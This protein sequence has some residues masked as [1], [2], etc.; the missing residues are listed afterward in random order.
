MLGSESDRMSVELEKLKRRALLTS[1]F[2]EE[3]NN[4]ILFETAEITYYAIVY[5]A[6]ISN[7]NA[8]IPNAFILQVLYK[9]DNPRNQKHAQEWYKVY[10]DLFTRLFGFGLHNVLNTVSQIPKKYA[11]NKVHE[12][13]K[14]RIESTIEQTE[15]GGVPYE[16]IIILGAQYPATLY[17]KTRL[18]T[19]TKQIDWNLHRRKLSDTAF[20]MSLGVWRKLVY[21]EGGEKHWSVDG[22]FITEK[23]RPTLWKLRPFVVSE[24]RQYM[25]RKTLIKTYGP[26]ELTTGGF[27]IDRTRYLV[28]LFH[29]FTA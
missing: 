22:Y 18:Q 11:Q 15:E 17:T 7:Q 8:E 23:H 27:V 20:R 4:Q 28:P 9:P 16:P 5:L 26:N 12:Y 3:S 21:L 14:M 29:V 24:R 2:S 10:T 19:V 6:N 25:S 13:I 1:L